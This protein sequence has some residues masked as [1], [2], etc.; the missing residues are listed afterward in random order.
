MSDDEWNRAM[1]ILRLSFM[2][3]FDNDDDEDEDI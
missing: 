2:E 1:K 3:A